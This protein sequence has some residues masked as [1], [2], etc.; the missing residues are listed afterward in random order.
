MLT[1]GKGM[2]CT[3]CVV[4][5]AWCVLDIDVS[6]SSQCN[7]GFAPP[8]HETIDSFSLALP[9]VSVSGVSAATF[10]LCQ[11]GGMVCGFSV[12][13]LKNS[14]LGNANLV[15]DLVVH[16]CHDGSNVVTKT[17]SL[18]QN[19]TRHAGGYYHDIAYADYYQTDVF[20]DKDITNFSLTSQ[21]IFVD[22][23]LVLGIPEPFSVQTCP[24]QNAL[25][26]LYSILLDGGGNMTYVSSIGGVCSTRCAVCPVN[27]YC[28]GNSTAISCQLNSK[29]ALGSFERSSCV[30]DVGFTNREGVCYCPTGLYL[31]HESKCLACPEDALCLGDNL[32]R[33]C[34]ANASLS[35]GVCTCDNGFFNDSGICYECPV[36]FFC[37]GGVRSTCSNNSVAPYSGMSVCECGA[38]FY[39]DGSCHPCP[40]GSFCPGGAAEK[41]VPC[42][43]STYSSSLGSIQCTSCPPNSGSSVAGAGNI[44]ICECAPGFTLV[45]GL[46]MCVACPSGFYCPGFG[47]SSLPCTS[48]RYHTGSGLAAESECTPC[49]YGTYSETTG[50][51]L[52]SVCKACR[53]GTYQP[54]MGARAESH[55]L[56]CP[57]GSYGDSQ[58]L[59]TCPLCQQGTIQLSYEATTSSSCT[60]CMPGTYQTGEG[61]G[62]LAGCLQC[63]KGTYQTGVGQIQSSACILCVAGTYQS[64]IGQPFSSACIMCGAGEYQTRQGGQEAAECQQCVEGTYQ[65]GRGVATPCL[66]C[67]AGTYGTGKG[68]KSVAAGCVACGKGSYQTGSGAV[69]VSSCQ[70]CDAGTVQP[71][72][73]ADSSDDCFACPEGTYQSM[74]GGADFSSCLSCALGTYQPGVAASSARDC[75]ACGVGR[76]QSSLAAT[77]DT[78]CVL[79]PAGTYQSASA[80]G[81]RAQCIS[82]S[83]GFYQPMEGAAT[84]KSCTPC[85]A[86]TYQTA[87]GA[88]SGDGC[89][90]CGAGTY[91]SAKGAGTPLACVKCPRGTFQTG[92][93]MV[94]AESCTACGK[95]EY[96]SGLGMG[97]S[98]GQVC[99]H[100]VAGTYQSVEGVGASACTKC[101]RGK[102]QTAPGQVDCSLCK[103]GTYQPFEGVS[104]DWWCKSCDAGTYSSSTG[105]SSFGSCSPCPRGM[106]TDGSGATN[107]TSCG[108]GKYSPNEGGHTCFSCMSGTYANSTGSSGCFPCDTGSSM[109]RAGGSVCD[110]CPP[111][112]HQF[113]TGARDCIT[114]SSGFYQPEPGA[115]A[116]LSCPNGSY[117]PAVNQ[118]QCLTC[119]PGL[120]AHMEG[121][122]GCIACA[123]GTFQPNASSSSCMP[124]NAG[125]YQSMQGM[126]YCSLCN[127]GFYQPTRSSLT[128]IPCKSGEYQA[129]AGSVVCDKCRTGS[130]HTGTGA[131]HSEQCLNCSSGSYG[132]VQGATV[133]TLCAAGTYILEEGT[134]LCESCVYGSFQSSSGSSSCDLCSPGTYSV[135]LGLISRTQCIPCPAGTFSTASGATMCTACE[136]GMF[137]DLEGTTNCSQCQ[138]GTYV[139]ERGWKRRGCTPC[140]EGTYSGVTGAVSLLTCTFCP[141]GFFSGVAGMV[142][143]TGCRQCLAGTVSVSN[144]SLCRTCVEG[145][146]CPAGYH[147]P[148]QCV[149]GLWCNGTHMDSA[150]GLLTY[151]RGNCTGAIPCPRGTQCWTRDSLMGK[152][153]LQTSQRNQTHFVVF[154]GGTNSTAMSCQGE[155]LNYGYARVD[156]PYVDPE[157]FQVLYRLAPMACPVGTYLH[158]DTC[159][160]CPAGTYSSKWSALAWDSCVACPAGTY[161]ALTGA[162]ACISCPVGGF[163]RSA[164]LTTWQAC[165]AGTYQPDQGMTVCLACPAGSFSSLPK[166]GT[167]VTCDAGTYQPVSGSTRCMT[168]AASQFSS[169]GDHICSPCGVDLV[170]LDPGASCT[171]PSLPDYKEG[172]TWISLRGAGDSD[173]CLSTGPLPVSELSSPNH[174]AVSHVI[175]TRVPVSCT[176]TLFVVDRAELRKTWVT[177]VGTLRRPSGLRVIPFNNTFYPELCKR[178]GFGVLFTVSDEYGGMLTDLTGARATMSMLDLTGQ[179]T[180]FSMGCDR[181]PNDPNA[182]IPIG[183][184][185]TSF[186]PTM[187]VVVRV[188]LT[189]MPAS[190]NPILQGQ[191]VLNPGPLGFCPPATSW[192][193]AVRLLNPSVPYMPGGEFDVQVS[194]LNPPPETKLVVFRFAIRVLGGVTLL[195]FQSAYSVVTETL[196]NTISVVG[197][198]SLGGGVILGTLRFRVDATVSGV[199]IV[200]QV[201]PQSFQ[202]T[203]V[204]AVPYTMSVRTEGF[205]CRSDGYID[206]L[207]DTPRTTTLITL[208]RK[209][210]VV[211]W[212]RIQTTAADLPTGIHVV[213]VNNVMHSFGAVVA[214]C[215]SVDYRNFDIAS[216]DVIRAGN[217]GNQS[218]LVRVRYQAVSVDVELES[219]I[220]VSGSFGI[221]V[222]PGGVSGRYR[223]RVTLVAGSRTISSVDA[224]PFLSKLIGF[225]VLLDGGQWKCFRPGTTFTIG[226][227]TMYTAVCGIP[228]IPTVQATPKSFFLVS[229]PLWGASALGS[230]VFPPAV[231]SAAMP[232]GGLILISPAGSSISLLNHSS[233]SSLGQLVPFQSRPSATVTLQNTGSSARC[234]QLTLQPMLSDAWAPFTAAIPVFPA[235]PKSLRVTLSTYVILSSQTET[236]AFIPSSTF[237]V[238]ASLVFSDG[239]QLPVQNDLRLRMTSTTLDVTGLAAMAPAALVGNATLVFTFRG[240][241]CVTT[242]VMLRVV[243]TSVL[244]TTLVCPSCP[245][246]IALGSDPLSQQMPNAFP[247]A[248]PAAFI[249]VRRLLLDGRVVTRYEPV[250]VVSGTSVS[251]L[252][253]DVLG[254]SSGVSLLSTQSTPGQTISVTVLHRWVTEARLVCNGGACNSS[255]SLAPIGDGASLPPFQYATSLA[256]SLSVTLVNG[257]VMEFPWLGGFS[258]VV[259]E[260]D[261]QGLVLSSLVYGPLA[262]R[263]RIDSTWDIH[264]HE[265]SN[266]VQLQVNTLSSLTVAGPSVLF[267]VHC[268]GFWEEAHFTTTGILSDGV[269]HV[270]PADYGVSGPL[271]MHH[272]SGLFHASSV[273]EARITASFGGQQAVYVVEAVETSKFFS[274]LSLDFLP[275]YWNA[276][277]GAELRL[278]PSL[279]PVLIDE[280]WFPVS[281]LTN[282]VL[283]W[284]SSSPAVIEVTSDGSS[285]ILHRDSYHPI[286]LTAV[287]KACAGAPVGQTTSF[288]KDIT[289][290]VAPQETGDIDIGQESGAPLELFPVGAI[291]EIPVFI[292]VARTGS[293]SA[294]LQSYMVEA[295]VTG[296]GVSVTECQAGSLP[297]SQCALV[298]HG[299][300][301]GVGAF[302]QSQ[303]HGRIR[304]LTMRFMVLLDALAFVHVRL[305]Q[306]LVDGALVQPHNTTYVIRLGTGLLADN[307]LAPLAVPLLAGARRVL[308]PSGVAGGVGKV[309]GDTDADGAFTALDVLFMENYIALGVF[310]GVQQICVVR[311]KCQLTTR[312]SVWQLQQMKPVRHPMLPATRPDGS[313]VLFL[314][315]ALV[316][317]TFFL[318]TVDVKASPGALVISVGLRDYEQHQNP[319]NAVVKLGLVTTSNRGLAF[320][321]QYVFDQGASMLTVT[322]QH[323]DE[324]FVARTLASSATFDELSVGLR[325]YVRALDDMGSPESAVA[326][327]RFFVFK[328][329]GPISLFNIIGSQTLLPPAGPTVTYLPTLNCENLC[330]DASLFLDHTLSTPVWLNRTAVNVSFVPSLPPVFRGVWKGF[331]GQTF[332]PSVFDTTIVSIP[333]DEGWISVGT[334]FNLSLPIPSDWNAHV[335]ALFTVQSSPPIPLV[336]VHGGESPVS[337]GGSNVFFTSNTAPWDVNLEFYMREEGE[338]VITVTQVDSSS[339]VGQGQLPMAL[340]QRT[341]VGVADEITELRVTP[342]CSHT[343]V[344]L[345]SRFIPSAKDE[346]C[347]VKVSAYTSNGIEITSQTLVCSMYPCLLQAFGQVIRPS[348]RV[349]VPTDAR[350]LVQRPVFSVGHQIQWRI[351]CDAED[352]SGF[353]ITERALQA[354]LIRVH[355]PNTLAVMPDKIR[356]VTAGYATLSF[357]ADKI[358]IGLNVTESLNVPRTLDV[359]P[360]KSVALSIPVQGETGLAVFQPP[361]FIA[362]TRFF[363]LIR[364][365]YSGGYT[366]LLDPA[367]GSDGVSLTAVSDDLVVSQLDGSVLVR[368]GA[369]GG[370]DIPLVTVEY[371]GVT[372]VVRGD[373]VP[374]APVR[375]ELCCDAV[376]ASRRSN[377]FGHPSFQSSFVI[378]SLRV[379][380]DEGVDGSLV[381]KRLRLD[382]SAIR[383]AHDSSVV[384]YDHVSEVWTLQD[385]APVH[386]VSEITVFYTHPKTMDTVH[387]V[388]TVTLVEAERM[389]VTGPSLLYRIHCASSLFQSGHV[390]ATLHLVPSLSLSSDVDVTAEFVLN[391]SDSSIVRVGNRSVTGQATGVAEITV[392]ARGLIAFFSVEVSDASVVVQS[393]SVP[394]LYDLRGVKGVTRFPV[395]LDGELDNGQGRLDISSLGIFSLDGNPFVSLEP[396]MDA[397]QLGPVFIIRATSFT[398]TGVQLHVTLPACTTAPVTGLALSASSL[399][400]THAIA[401]DGHADVEIGLVNE[402]GAVHMTLILVAPSPVLAFYIQLHTDSSGFSECTPLAGLPTFS[403]CVTG[404]P[405]TGDVIVAGAVSAPLQRETSLVTLVSQSMFSNAWGFVEVFN[406]FSAVRYSIQAGEL[407]PVVREGPSYHN[408]SVDLLMPGLPT[409]DTGALSRSFRGLFSVPRMQGVRDVQQQ[410]LVLTNRLRNVDTRVYSNEFE[411]SIMFFVTDRFL[412]PDPNMTRIRVHLH[413]DQ[414][415][416]PGSAPDQLGGVWVTAAHVLDGWYAV[417]LRQKIPRL[418]L[419]ISFAVSTPLSQNEWLW[420]LALPVEIG[421]PVPTCP[422]SASQTATFLASYHISVPEDLHLLNLTAVDIDGLLGQVACSVQV[423]SRRVMLSSQNAHSL[424]LTVALESLTRVH[425]ANLVLMG[426]WLSEELERRI[427]GRNTSYGPLISIERGDVSFINDTS[428]P[429]RPCP[430]GFFFSRNGTYMFLP[431]HATAGDDCYD[432]FCSAG[433]TASVAEVTGHVSCVPTPVSVDVVWVCVIVILTGI[434]AL[435]SLACCIKLALWTTAKDI[436]DVVFDPS[437]SSPLPDNTPDMPVPSAPSADWGPYHCDEDNPF[438]D[439]VDCE[440]YFKNVVTEMGMDELSMTMMMDDDSPR[441]MVDVP[442][443]YGHGSHD[444]S[445]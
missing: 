367:P 436:H 280:P 155:V 54:F 243:G 83:A 406:G 370:R 358:V 182:K 420:H 270:V 107:C 15:R 374:L 311:G 202:F 352:M 313:D 226:V 89:V 181:L 131:N 331:A 157:G 312:L 419:M 180:L 357:G 86:G 402:N 75:L 220:P 35:G 210:Y 139:A 273:G 259:N 386:G 211:N 65:S 212:R 9:P 93:A 251:V 162:S 91:Q 36:G 81:G 98:K 137:S 22:S 164:R 43:P 384:R 445:T 256:V 27:Y 67:A 294:R 305:L 387:A 40:L 335:M 204:N 299:L 396:S 26:G 429:P 167:C 398:S 379:F 348:I 277:V 58:G 434:L 381:S 199:G 177:S 323:T 340:V 314:L 203:L 166:S 383:V 147:D 388:L 138:A 122:S 55:C 423:A 49:R 168:C 430:S 51:S 152:G 69:N 304:V 171:P 432:M 16:C 175:M 334:N 223:V 249:M 382:D 127:P 237:V 421:V 250:T 221:V 225:G 96:S 92:V 363:L 66:L 229:G 170:S 34:L 356:G 394:A 42:L 284:V 145:E 140:P 214:S 118:S 103:E 200:A 342:L 146:F 366:L 377:M 413:T 102:F 365:V 95:G 8:P 72:L 274:G 105:A 186:C 87:V 408:H 392:S 347:P 143:A 401:A 48:G 136:E 110:L 194:V 339:S 264:A 53:I 25:H 288:S 417:E 41:T 142:S 442:A 59:S 77:S 373:I 208:P 3:V 298:G 117:Q 130:Y 341:V 78:E 218:G 403:D 397:T 422:R 222:S 321:T 435:A 404:S 188:T 389:D 316:G 111:G 245:D 428:D 325:L 184:C 108:Y 255:I 56:R 10:L 411:L 154:E 80:A 257:S 283:R 190:L 271:V 234:V 215:V 85:S 125:E 119:S 172:I 350:I 112:Q 6:A 124:C 20:F 266:G 349:V 418:S 248:F 33:P 297:N 308:L 217:V 439:P 148:I 104:V 216:C 319:S 1:D 149:P 99:L 196:G 174:V 328:P 300:F 285:I 29:S 39:R 378:S 158:Y 443:Y 228:R 291:M 5:V 163:C 205:S 191:V 4:L 327:D 236:D 295:E 7:V 244:A 364:V 97:G 114:C 301:R 354:G 410:L 235:G 293:S 262:V 289:V 74:L 109:S 13:R 94:S 409:V 390:S 344:F 179:N 113:L 246:V 73:G 185:R 45:P 360:F 336:T 306:G 150:A 224:T 11:E 156:W 385:G 265:I 120:Y 322:C 23:V 414:I 60:G 70:I 281:Q 252:D 141:N 227:P 425:Q 62:S 232:F 269:T 276:S 230:Y 126:T 242:S 330:D 346:L 278:I 18:V 63:P 416:I 343:G 238:Q 426:G 106:T 279:S 233:L 132:A 84:S 160:S 187:S 324:G 375:L 309:F 121:M 290:N 31:S 71:G 431:P 268:S 219:W 128:C 76:Y 307:S 90:L 258:L 133:C 178:Q 267:Q 153:L 359:I 286:T 241:P 14:L 198:A 261:Y 12:Y 376:L 329:T 37:A 17:I 32:A 30:C 437:E 61:M 129:N 287:F 134:T 275:T 52:E 263:V 444:V 50:A 326:Q 296:S 368:S 391:S 68:A 440:A 2:R 355:P 317:K 19:Y 415:E 302:A 24:Q 372:T 400:R 438:H 441:P 201:V 303:L 115:T 337:V 82:C 424:L 338:Y 240:I 239:T 165:K 207:L 46:G 412:R 100:C 209:T 197:D 101:E 380:L 57:P 213:S 333:T 135:T 173:E 28:P 433:Y 151:T 320:D 195:S 44:S 318:D 427:I 362:G 159:V 407:S 272:S 361:P 393:L 231:I 371:Q 47:S 254:V 123:P 189:W 351:E 88:S 260:S 405:T 64:K 315:M 38:G 310:Q 169:P 292:Y 399:V 79:C 144:K 21:S 176:S 247:S 116:C 332:T 183:V 206:V 369:M 193:A 282:K 192:M 161:N 353:T 345:W 395:R 253:G